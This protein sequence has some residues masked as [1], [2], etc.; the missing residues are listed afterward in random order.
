[1]SLSAPIVMEFGHEARTTRKLLERLPDEK[2]GWTPHVKSMPLGRL[3]AHLAEIPG[4]FKGILEQDELDF[5]A[6][7]YQP[8]S[9]ASRVEALESFDGAVAAFSASL[10]G[11]SDE[12]MMAPWRLRNGDH[13]F[14]EL[15]RI[16]V[17]RSMVLSH[18][19]HH[20]GQLAVYLR[21][22]D[23][24]VPSIYGPSADEAM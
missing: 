5:G 18:M 6:A 4:W 2:L 16:A 17:V 13:V 14:F 11:Q 12:R 7:K 23:V 19:I 3:A 20:R 24:P 8:P 10:K 21:L 9:A 15:P 22:L 1:M